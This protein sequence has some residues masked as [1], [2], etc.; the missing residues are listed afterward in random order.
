MSQPILGHHFTPRAVTALT[1]SC[2]PPAVPAL[3]AVCES[4]GPNCVLSWQVC[5]ICASM[6]WGDPNYRS[7]NFMEHLQ[8]RHR[9]S[10]D[11]F[12]VGVGSLGAPCALRGLQG[13][14]EAALLLP[15]SCSLAAVL[16]GFCVAGLRC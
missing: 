11:T 12:V 10:Y 2:T 13:H 16:R 8:R 5:P 14:R 15:C 9:F 1:L 3:P 6:P 7:A 4:P